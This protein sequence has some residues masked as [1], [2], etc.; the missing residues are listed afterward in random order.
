[1]TPDA[2]RLGLGVALAARPDLV[3][4]LSR[5]RS[6]VAAPD[7]L[8]RVLTRALGVRYAVQGLAGVV[9]R[10]PWTPAADAAVDLLHA[11]SMVLVVAADRRYR[12]PAAVSALVATALAAAD[13]RTRR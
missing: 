10:R 12:R 13:L 9:A 1:M 8:L 11:A 2:A 4:R 5:S 6:R 7:E 3:D